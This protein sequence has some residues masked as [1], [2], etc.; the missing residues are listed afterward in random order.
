MEQ[1]EEVIRGIKRKKPSVI[2]KTRDSRNFQN[3]C[4]GRKERYGKENWY[5]QYLKNKNK[6]LCKLYRD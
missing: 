4:A 1:L 6:R 5:Y 3:I 2:N